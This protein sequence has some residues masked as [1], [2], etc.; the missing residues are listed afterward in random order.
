MM[1]ELSDST[2]NLNIATEHL[3]CPGIERRIIMSLIDTYIKEITELLKKCDDV[4]MLDLIF[5]LLKKHSAQ[6]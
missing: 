1:I 4:Q 2:I 5:Q 3:F 6:S